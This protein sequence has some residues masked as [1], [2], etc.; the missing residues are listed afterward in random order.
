M[1][2]VIDGAKKA[3]EFKGGLRAA[4]QAHIDATAR[5]RDYDSGNSLAGYVDD[6][7][8]PW[9]AEAAAFVAWRSSVWQFVFSWLAAV[10]AG[11]QA[12]PESADALVAALPAME[13]PD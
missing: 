7:H 13:W 11:T 5:E 9:A 1:R 10:E 3:A 12:P 8:E 6:P 2:I 4:V